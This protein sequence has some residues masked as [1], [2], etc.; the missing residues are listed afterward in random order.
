MNFKKGIIMEEDKI[1]QS[2][3][4]KTLLNDNLAQRISGVLRAERDILSKIVENVEGSGWKNFIKALNLLNS[5]KGRVIITGMGKSGHIGK[6]VA[7][8][9]SSLGAT[10]HFVHPGEAS[11]GD[12]GMITKDDA[13]IAFSN[14]GNTSELK[15]ILV[16]SKNINV[17]VVGVTMGDQSLLAKYSTV[18]IIIPKMPEGC[19]LGLAPTTSTTAQLAYG[20]ALSVGL[21]VLRD[22]DRDN[23]HKL[24]PGGS[25]GQSTTKVLEVMKTEKCLPLVRKTSK[26]KEI[27]WE[28]AQKSSSL[29][30]VL[31]TEG[32][33]IGIIKATEVNPDKD[34]YAEEIMRTASPIINPDDSV[35]TA[36]S[37]MNKNALESIFVVENDKPIGFFKK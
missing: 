25:L 22:F 27:V 2:T 6:K 34:E 28:M 24:H 21:S 23:F 3:E 35:A 11:H 7:A 37:R 15:D 33:L 14:S 5:T 17:P 1:Y 31:N 4:A 9:M 36:V 8:T 18:P 16:Y 30:G 13:L 19:S 26:T 29:V 20:D 10:A 32:L 12:L